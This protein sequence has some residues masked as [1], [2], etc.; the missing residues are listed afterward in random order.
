MMVTNKPS[1]REFL[2]A[3]V[4][5]ALGALIV[6]THGRTV[7]R[8]QARTLYVGTYTNS[9]KS[10]GIYVYRMDTSSGELTRIHSVQAVNPSY[11][12]LDRSTRHLYAVNEV[13]QFEGKSSGAVSAFRIDPRTGDPTFLNQEPSLGADPCYVSLDRTGKFLLVANYTGGNVSVFPIRSDGSLGAATD[14]VQHEGSSVHKNQKGPHAHC[15]MLDPTNRFALAADLGIDKVLVYRF[16]SMHGK[17]RPARELWASL[18]P[19]AGP[20]H[21]T[22]HPR[23]RFLFAINE[24]DSTISV[25]SYDGRRGSLREVQT[26]STLPADFSGNNSCADVHVSPSGRFLYGSNRG[27]DSIVVFWIDQATGRLKQVEHVSTQGKT[28]RNFTLD[29]SDTFL[30]VANQNS[31][32]VVTFRVDQKTGKLQPTGHV[33]EIPVPVCL[34]FA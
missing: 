11:L 9:G 22:F 18:K 24:L 28:P 4:V 29:P 32:T 31:D 12:A 34:K 19:G 13:D 10:E 15:F 17:L 7:L 30:L 26:I 3:S 27:H 23:G 2:K 8:A 1:R 14:H 33:A 5:G 20:R 16:D 6:P 25:F 21:L